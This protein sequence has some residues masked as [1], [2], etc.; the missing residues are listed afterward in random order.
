MSK[1]PYDI[2]NKLIEDYLDQEGTTTG[3]YHI[4]SSLTIIVGNR[5]KS[6]REELSKAEGREED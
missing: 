4:L 1:I 2:I 5:S 6:L 3:T